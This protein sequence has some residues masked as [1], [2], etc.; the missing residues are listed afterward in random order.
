MSQLLAIQP[1][2]QHDT[3]VAVLQR[4]A[5]N[6]AISSW[7]SASAG[8]GKTKV[9]T[10][11]ILRLLL[12]Q[13]DGRPGTVP[14]KILALTFTKAAA[15]EMAAR[16]R[17]RLS[18]WA[19]MDDTDLQ[20]KLHNLLGEEASAEQVKAARRLFAQV[21]DAPGGLPI[22]TIH[23]FC[24][25]V[26]GRFPLEAGITPDFT[27]IEG[28]AQTTLMD[29][30]KRHVLAD[31]ARD[32]S[33]PL[34]MAWGRLAPRLD[35]EKLDALLANIRKEQGQLDHIR[36]RG[37]SLYED[38]ARALGVRPGVDINS[39]IADFCRKN[40][41]DEDTLRRAATI[42]LDDG[43]KQN[44]GR[45]GPILNWLSA[46]T[47]TRIQ[48]YADYSR[49]FLTGDGQ[50]FN[51]IAGKPLGR[52]HDFL[53]PC[54][55]TEAQAIVSLNEDMA[56]AECAQLTSDLFLFAQGVLGEY[57][58]MK[59]RRGLLDFDDLIFKTLDLLQGRSMK[60]AARDATAWV[61]YKLDQGIDHILVDEAQDT[62]PEQWQVIESLSDDFFN[63]TSASNIQR[64]L[65]V[66]GDQKQSIFSFQRAAPEKFHAMESFFREKI[67]AAKQG[68][69]SVPISVSFRSARAVLQA[70]D[71][72][73][74]NPVLQTALGGHVS[75]HLPFRTGQPGL[76]ELW[77]M[78]ETPTEED[79]ALLSLPLTIQE[80]LSG[81]ARLARDMAKTIA[82]WIGKEDLPSHGRKIEA[83]DIMVLVRTRNAFV[84]Q[85]VRALKLAGVP[86][87]GVDRM[88]LKDQLAVQDMMAAMHFALLPEDDL[89]LAELLKSPLVGWN[90]D[91]LI[92][93]AATRGEKTLW[94][95]LQQL[96]AD[97]PATQ[98]LRRLI[99]QAGHIGVYE[100][101]AGILSAPCPG[102]ART[103][104]QAM[105]KRLGPE[106]LDPLEELQNAALTFDQQE[107]AG[108]QLFLQQFES[109][110]S[111]IKRQ[112]D[113]GTDA[114]R[115]MTVHASKG[116]QAP[117]VFL[118]DTTRV[119]ASRKGESLYWPYR[120][121]Q[122]LP[123]F[124]P[125]KAL[126][127]RGAAQARARYE[128]LAEEE[129]A[130]LLYVAMTR[131]EDRLYIAG[132]KGTRG[133]L[134]Q[135]WYRYIENA[136]ERLDGVEVMGEIKRFTTPASDQPDRIKDKKPSAEKIQVA[137]TWL[138]KPAPIEAD[139]P[140]P[141]VPSR[142]SESDTDVP[143]LSPLKAADRNRFKRGNIIHK[144]LQILPDVES[145]QRAAVMQNYLAQPGH[146]LSAELQASIA[147]E[148]SSLL[149][150]PDFAHV[151]SKE[152]LSEV[153][154]T[155]L[156][157]EKTLIS[158]QIDRLVVTDSEV[159][160]VDFKTNRPPPTEVK[161]VPGVYTRQM[162]AYRRA[163]QLIYPEKKIRTALL[164]TMG[165]RLMEV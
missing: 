165:A 130:R 133:I 35:E 132:Y 39:L 6:P 162:D 126:A 142:P 164:W 51:P 112:M 106:A 134:D 68:F 145:S 94:Q 25:S 100:F 14:H 20:K 37:L 30:A 157:D 81:S 50:P 65:F 67:W 61:M 139:P 118:P 116:L 127:V 33:S 34:G 71:A 155:G 140:R 82:G 38:V 5:A 91:D 122:P 58:R 136:F 120:S 72:T 9:L 46:D 143:T 87:S 98:W 43:G 113:D 73:F 2:L 88:I 163:L 53:E 66:V 15:S 24:Q 63:G 85:L 48:M 108:L 28:T 93:I 115:I 3:N 59:T 109:G 161:D 76:V 41:A 154:L 60:R 149:T 69:E 117:I 151:F 101:C 124:A 4:R 18:E 42:M 92:N 13:S 77:P 7:V 114:V 32:S 144:L 159:L 147:H 27:L 129:Y 40:R 47:D 86:V 150:H 119:S 45:A 97:N 79:S 52:A 141:L 90:D 19:V 11:R 121:D 152:A 23:A 56:A 55:Q 1:P 83:G 21:I 158:G 137:P 62:N 138:F 29:Q 107:G 99:E 31:I 111:E 57:D 84:G 49:A 64:T 153:P 54:L 123:Y 128:A 110:A 103:G 125:E 22:M 160:I 74:N 102:D 26:L 80:S 148:V 96:R 78:Y 8:S 12:P 89:S 44:T 10:D 16:V 104:L 146:D 135:S 36:T 75:S 17:T 156:L 95:S 70:V 105:K 131:A